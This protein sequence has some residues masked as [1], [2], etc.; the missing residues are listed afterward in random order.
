MDVMR[1]GVMLLTLGNGLYINLSAVSP[2]GKI[3]AFELVAAAGAGFL[4]QP[5]LIALQAHVDPKQTASATATLGLVRNLATSLSIVVSG[6][7]F[8]NGMDK[9]SHILL[10]KGLS[11]NLTASF[12]GSGAAAHVMLV[13]TI[14]DPVQQFAVKE[15]YAAS[16]RSIWILCT[17]MSSCAAI[18]CVFVAKKELSKIHVEVRTGLEKTEPEAGVVGS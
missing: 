14:E 6:V 10:E 3:I 13:R 16:L 7:A 9:Q 11:W 12:T 5:P 2:L 15:A 1:I 18:A 8:A 17:C 4:F